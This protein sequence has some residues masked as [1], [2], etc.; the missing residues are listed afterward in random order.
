MEC[1]YCDDPDIEFVE[2]LDSNYPEEVRQLAICNNCSEGD[3]VLKFS[4]EEVS[5]ASE[6]GLF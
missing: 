3:I 4:L 2:T 1:P 5:K 6:E